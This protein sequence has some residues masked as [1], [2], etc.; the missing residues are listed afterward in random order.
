MV[1]AL[2]QNVLSYPIMHPRVC[3]C[4]PRITADINS[5][6]RLVEQMASHFGKELTLVYITKDP[7]ILQLDFSTVLD[8][9][10]AFRELFGVLDSDVPMM[11]RK[12]PGLL[13]LD[14][15]EL[16]QRYDNVRELTRFNTQQV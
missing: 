8:R 3:R 5:M 13:A 6:T 7:L 9:I 15:Q 2:I 16:R 12:H 14:S 11:L 10:K 4:L 1:E